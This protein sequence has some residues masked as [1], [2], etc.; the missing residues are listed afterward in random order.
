VSTTFAPGVARGLDAGEAARRLAEFGPNEL[1]PQRPDRLVARI[2]RQLAEPMAF[3]L[4]AAAAVAWLA[5]GERVDAVAIGAIVAA[6]VVIAL[7]QE[8]K[9][10][11]ALDALR[12]METPSATVVRGGVAAVIPS[13]QIVPGDLILLSAGDRVP[14]DLRLIETS[15]MEV[16]ESILTGESLPAR[17]DGSAVD[18]GGGLGDQRAMAFSGTLVVHGSGKGLAVAT[19][20][21]TQLGAIAGRLD[22]RE[23]QTPL[24][25]ELRK[26]TGRLGVIAIA[27]ALSVFGITLW[28]LGSSS[29]GFSNAFLTAAA[30]AVA[31]VPEGLPTVVTVALALGVRRMAT[32]GSIVRRLPA[33]ETLGS[34]TVILTDKTGTLTQNRMRVDSVCAVDADPVPFAALPDPVAQAA[35]EV[36]ALCNDATLEPPTG[37]PMEVALL[38]ALGASRVAALRDA[39]PQVAEL[40]FDSERKRMTSANRFGEG[41]RLLM[42]GAPEVVLDRCAAAIVRD[43]GSRSL[44]A[45]DRRR[46]LAVAEELAGM[47]GRVLALARR[48]I[49]GDRALDREENDL[50][51]VGLVT[52]RDPV[53][54]EA[55]RAV[56]EA[57]AAG[58]RILM[59]TG[60]HPGTALAIAREVALAPGGAEVITGADIRRD[61]FPLDPLDVPVYARVDPDEKLALAEALQ[62][63][64]HVVAVTGDGVNDAP[65][66]RRADIGVAMGR[67]GSDVAREAADMVVTDDDLATIVTAVREGRGIYDN[68]RKVV[69]YLVAGNLSEIMVVVAGLVFFPGLGVP[70]L[71]LQLLWINLLTDGFPA[72]ALGV[73]PVDRGLMER[74]PRPQA[75]HLLSRERLTMLLWRASLIA[76]AAVGSLAIARYAWGEPWPHAR[77]T[78]F[79]VLMTAH[80]LYAFAV[81]RSG[82]PVRSN[83]W[84]YAAVGGSLALQVAVVIT[85]A[86][87]GVFGTAPLSLRE[88]LL[89]VGAG[90][91]PP[92]LIHA[93]AMIGRRRRTG[94]RDGHQ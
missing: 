13:P 14:A 40:P 65:A 22:E 11:R 39:H 20:A 5:L 91:L 45:E 64:G 9:A 88:W 44:D 6:N 81:R 61:G 46:V 7:I 69:D 15:S 84:L 12:E 72:L 4:I 16:D 93:T 42:K 2:A 57:A 89:V 26:L 86:L 75:D 92:F 33:V 58:I 28:R 23:Q 43:G 83:R 60:D 27:I 59:V 17:K 55:A 36:L 10:A 38:A 85:P 31:A 78:M 70:L 25:R 29:G 63:R 73:D 82:S 79:S 77:A 19:G 1:P 62:A 35:A 37:D 66:L 90:T 51:L 41:V 8:G 32:H 68:I 34:T 50:T 80:L 52:L 53:R 94:T 87:R 54:P 48:T 49:S 18:G 24:Q 21:R 71:P 56:A 30:L 3:L 76:G 67:S 74:P 47:G